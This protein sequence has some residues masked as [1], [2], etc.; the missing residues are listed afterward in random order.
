MDQSEPTKI[1]IDVQ[2]ERAEI[3]RLRA[4]ANTRERWL[5]EAIKRALEQA[6]FTV[7]TPSGRSS[8]PEPDFLISQSTPPQGL[9]AIVRQVVRAFGA[10]EFNVRTIEGF[11]RQQ[12]LPLPEKHTRDRIS[13]VLKALTDSGEINIV[14]VGAG[15]EPHVYR[16]ATQLRSVTN[17]QELMA[18]G[19]APE[20]SKDGGLTRETSS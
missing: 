6:G 15:R 2:K 13:M 9:T 19:T 11:A 4:E 16:A 1:T 20:G 10:V 18:N 14:K 3:A 5:E 8:I 12:G 7:V 17:Q